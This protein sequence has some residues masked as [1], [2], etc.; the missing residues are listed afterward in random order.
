MSERPFDRAA[1]QA[2]LLRRRVVELAG[3]VA[4]D[5]RR[6]RTALQLGD[7]EIDDLVVAGRRRA[8]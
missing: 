5:H 2:E 4:A 7:A 3:E 6:V 1:E 8:E